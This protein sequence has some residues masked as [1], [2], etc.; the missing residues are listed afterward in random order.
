MG[1]EKQNKKLFVSAVSEHSYHS[2]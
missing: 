1:K 2:V